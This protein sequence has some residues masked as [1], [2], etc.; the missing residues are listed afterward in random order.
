[1]Y[2]RFVGRYIHTT[3]TIVR[4]V[5]PTDGGGGGC[6][7]NRLSAAAAAAYD[8]RVAA[9]TAA[10][11]FLATAAAH[12]RPVKRRVTLKRFVFFFLLF[13]HYNFF[14]SPLPARTHARLRTRSHTA[15]PDANLS[16]ARDNNRHTTTTLTREKR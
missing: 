4:D 11:A 7:V 13:F 14:F 5:K 3:N 1:M 10:A 9:T 15:D 8:L 2:T 12:Q 6:R 16:H